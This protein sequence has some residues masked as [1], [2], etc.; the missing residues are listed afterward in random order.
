MRCGDDEKTVD[1]TSS[2]LA[3]VFNYTVRLTRCRNATPLGFARATTRQ[4]VFAITNVDVPSRRQDDKFRAS[5]REQTIV[6]VVQFGGVLVAAR[7]SGNCTVR[8][9]EMQLT[10]S[11][12]QGGCDG[13][14][15]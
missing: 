10:R 6:R 7:S 5:P 2:L 4:I 15:T 14:Q 12:T 1:K 8:D 11:L 3:S 9:D 13:W